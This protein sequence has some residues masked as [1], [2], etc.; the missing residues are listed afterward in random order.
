MRTELCMT[1]HVYSSETV[2]LCCSFS[3][4]VLV[5]HSSRLALNA[6]SILTPWEL[7]FLCRLQYTSTGFYTVQLLLPP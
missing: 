2:W 4:E 6:M 1:T 7:V 5:P 3:I